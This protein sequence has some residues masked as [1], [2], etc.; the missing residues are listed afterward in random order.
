MPKK[1]EMTDE[2]FIAFINENKER[3]ENLMGKDE[4]LKGRVK[5]KAKNASLK[6]DE[7]VETTQDNVKNLF[8]ALFSSNVQKHFF[9]AGM[10]LMLGFSEI[11]KAIPVP[12]KVQPV[13]DKVSEA[14]KNAKEVHCAKNPD[15]P[16]KKTKTEKATVEK[17]ELD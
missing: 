17:I 10:E 3:M 4:G 2:E 8:S 6:L 14:R 11:I 9:S 16:K 7:A 5:E 1:K 13:V 12:Q 15:C